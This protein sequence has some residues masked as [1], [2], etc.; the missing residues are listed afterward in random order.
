M[1]IAKKNKLHIAWQ[2]GQNLVKVPDIPPGFLEGLPGKP[3]SKMY[4][5][6]MLK[7]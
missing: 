4:R 5:V 2:V 7:T 3:N 6:R 1:S